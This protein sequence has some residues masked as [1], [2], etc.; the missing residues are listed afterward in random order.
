M[1]KNVVVSVV[2]C[3]LALTFGEL[4]LRSLEIPKF[5]RSHSSPVQFRF[6][7]TGPTSFTYTNSPDTQICFTYD[8][9]PRGY[10]NESNTVCHTTNKWGFRG[11]EFDTVKAENE[12]R[13]GVLGDSFTFGEGV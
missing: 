6:L 8:G 3:I 5:Y 9:N 4:V 12:L 2:A 11:A 10:F 7:P 13:I 1:L